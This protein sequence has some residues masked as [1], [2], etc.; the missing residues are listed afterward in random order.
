MPGCDMVIFTFTQIVQCFFLPSSSWYIQREAEFIDGKWG[1]WSV[2]LAYLPLCCR[3][4][5]TYWPPCWSAGEVLRR[6]V[7]DLPKYNSNCIPLVVLQWSTIRLRI[8]QNFGTYYTQRRMLSAWNFQLNLNQCSIPLIVQQC[9]LL[10]Q[11]YGSNL[12]SKMAT[13][14]LK[15]LREF[16]RNTIASTSIHRLP[17]KIASLYFLV[18]SLLQ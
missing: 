11:A 10:E 15:R 12:T 14:L 9:K 8:L 3:E 4:L 6:A 1:I 17:W 18:T 13:Q 7:H 5:S 16:W 2:C